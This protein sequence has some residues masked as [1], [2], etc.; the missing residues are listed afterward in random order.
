M[1]YIIIERVL[2]CTLSFISR[3]NNERPVIVRIKKL[4]GG[5]VILNQLQNVYR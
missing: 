1:M 2:Y 5:P 4:S 3:E